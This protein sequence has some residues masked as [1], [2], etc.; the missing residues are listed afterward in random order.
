[1]FEIGTETEN[2]KP[3]SKTP[4]LCFDFDDDYEPIV[5]SKPL[6]K[7][8]AEST[9]IVNKENNSARPTIPLVSRV[10][11]SPKTPQNLRQRNLMCNSADLVTKSPQLLKNISNSP[12][13][14]LAMISS[15]GKRQ[16]L[17]T[18]KNMRT[19]FQANENVDN[20]FNF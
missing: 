1:M 20:T 5:F 7:K 18:G 16:S 13:L 12:L 19:N 9:F 11:N 6:V 10:I 8:P 4:D 15:H 2:F 3:A 17:S 14:K